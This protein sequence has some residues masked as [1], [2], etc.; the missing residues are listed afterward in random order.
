M[1]ETPMSLFLQVLGEEENSF[2]IAQDSTSSHS[3]LLMKNATMP[4]MVFHLSI[5]MLPFHDDIC[6]ELFKYLGWNFK[7]IF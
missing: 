3:F 5:A 4:T 2:K 7:C 1:P 6:K